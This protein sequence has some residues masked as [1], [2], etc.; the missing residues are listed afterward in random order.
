MSDMHM[1]DNNNKHV[2]SMTAICYHDD[3][4]KF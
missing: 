3:I 4:T 2:Q 1:N